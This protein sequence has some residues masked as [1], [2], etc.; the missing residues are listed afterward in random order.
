MGEDCLLYTKWIAF[1]KASSSSA[2]VTLIFAAIPIILGLIVL[3]Y[4]KKNG[5]LK[6]TDRLFLLTLSL[7]GLV[8]WAG[9][10]VGPMILVISTLVP[11]KKS[12]I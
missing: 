6:N 9:L 10:I 12:K 1:T 11:I 4:L 5:Q 3:S 7:L 2:S 8:F